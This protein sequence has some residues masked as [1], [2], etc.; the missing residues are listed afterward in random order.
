MEV[1]GC[2]GIGV[3]GRRV[4]AVPS[5]RGL[6]REA[7]RSCSPPASAAQAL[8]PCRAARCVGPGSLAPFRPQHAP[9]TAGLPAAPVL[10]AS[11]SA[12]SA[13]AAAAAAWR[14]RSPSPT[15]DICGHS[16]GSGSPPGSLSLPPGAYAGQRPGSPTP[17]PTLGPIRPQLAPSWR[18]DGSL[19][20]APF[21]VQQ[22][23]RGL[24]PGLPASLSRGAHSGSTG[25]LAGAPALAR[26][27]PP[28]PQQQQAV[29][30]AAWPARSP[31]KQPTPERR[32]PS[33]RGAAATAAKAHGG[34]GGAQG[35]HSAAS[36]VASAAAAA[37]A[38]LATAGAP[39]MTTAVA[40]V[41][42][43]ATPVRSISTASVGDVAGAV[44]R[45]ISMGDASGA[46]SRGAS[47]TLSPTAGASLRTSLA[48]TAALSS[49]RSMP[50]LASFGTSSDNAQEADSPTAHACSSSLSLS[51]MLCCSPM[52][53]LATARAVPA[54][55]PTVSA[56]EA[57]TAR[58]VPSASA[59]PNSAEACVPLQT[60]KARL[61][62][63]PTLQEVPKGLAAAAGAAAAAA[64]AAAPTGFA[65]AEVPDLQHRMQVCADL[66]RVRQKIQAVA[67]EC[68]Q[69]LTRAQTAILS[70]AVP[71]GCSS[72]STISLPI[73]AFGG[74]T[75][76]AT[77]PVLA[78][79]QGH[80]QTSA[81]GALTR[82]SPRQLLPGLGGTWS[83]RASPREL[84]PACSAVLTRS[85][86]HQ[87]PGATAQDMEAGG[88]GASP[89]TR[90]FDHKEQATFFGIV[91]RPASP[92][93]PLPEL[94]NYISMSDA[95]AVAA[96]PGG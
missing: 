12:A 15:V 47:P 68:M 62:P 23:A 82:V 3:P 24:Q 1:A 18:S 67:D 64:A 34:T 16:A 65:G 40:V 38:A 30:L 22:P 73:G 14:G 32:A 83:P 57:V 77:A 17:T 50:A 56:A 48:T 33:P 9:P 46:A 59:T 25:S 92:P 39:V 85:P 95:L 55:A 21:V 8:P 70:G 41:G 44:S 5:Q 63:T 36:A 11:T 76:P 7:F 35:G 91:G 54:A 51:P 88:A 31:R 13:A 37:A 43:A 94:R 72:G 29:P 52:V 81:L 69:E 58:A 2:R 96:P 6:H 78:P 71:A 87:W 90:R 27:L 89:R 42:P 93:P 80:P 45:R 19:L 60:P 26:P 86:S 79:V 28:Q 10:L 66:E 20:G 49:S 75:T 61:A 53:P 74:T 4:A 84:S